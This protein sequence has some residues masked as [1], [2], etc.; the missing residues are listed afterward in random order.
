MGGIKAGTLFC[1]FEV[2]YTIF[3]LKDYKN[4]VKDRVISFMADIILIHVL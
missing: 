1:C 2:P 4:I 3:F